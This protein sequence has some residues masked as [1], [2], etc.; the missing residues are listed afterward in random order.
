MKKYVLD[1]YC[2]Q[3]Q[4]IETNKWIEICVTTFGGFL[5][6]KNYNFIHD[7]EKQIKLN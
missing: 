7:L 6:D 2:L 1:F 5:H 4:H 3:P